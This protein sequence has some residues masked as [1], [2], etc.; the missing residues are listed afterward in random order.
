MAVDNDTT[1]FTLKMQY[2]AAL[3]E[4]QQQQLLENRQSNNTR[5]QTKSHL[6]LLNDYLSEKKLKKLEEFT[7]VELP[8]L[9]FSFYTNVRKEEGEIYKL[10]S[11]KCIR[12]SINC[13]MKDNRNIDIIADPRFVK[14]NQMFKAVTVKTKKQGKAVTISKR[15]ISSEDMQKLAEYF[16]ND[17]EENPDPK[18]LQ[19]NVI[20]NILYFFVCCGH[21]NLPNMKQYW[22]AIK[23]DPQS[24]MRYVEQVQDELDKNHSPQDTKMTNE[25][26]MY[27]T[28]GQLHFTIEK[29]RENRDLIMLKFAIKQKCHHVTKNPFNHTFEQCQL[30]F[31]RWFTLCSEDIRPVH[32][33]TQ[34]SM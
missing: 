13:Y 11:I 6:R 18:L 20:F 2:F 24:R 25:G 34:P 1:D 31:S 33:E 10:A 21:E 27:E 8:D 26:R 29:S 3:N 9:L 32:P 17:Y 23:T 16:Q 30:I 19:E 4:D 22:F 15:V 14:A 5:V 28:A 12:A 7:D